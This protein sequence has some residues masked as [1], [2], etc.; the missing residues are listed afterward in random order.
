MSYHHMFHF[1]ILLTQILE[2]ITSFKLVQPFSNTIHEL[3]FNK[4]KFASNNLFRFQLK[5]DVTAFF[6]AENM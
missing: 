2:N 3:K 5:R 4:T 6:Q 1:F